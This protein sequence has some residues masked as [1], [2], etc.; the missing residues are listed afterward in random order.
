M[1]IQ[2]LRIK[3]LKKD[4][5]QDMSLFNDLEILIIDVWNSSKH[6]QWIKE[7]LELPL[8]IKYLIIRLN[9]IN[10]LSS[11]KIND[12][13][14]LKIPFGCCLYIE[15]NKYLYTTDEKIEKQNTTHI[16]DT[17][18]DYRRIFHNIS[19]YFCISTNA[20]MKNLKYI[21]GHKYFIDHNI[22]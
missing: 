12:L 1:K 17:N 14:K 3:D 8:N 15:S 21:L 6:L 7:G 9:H 18:M 20:D 4:F 16:Y 2:I 22:I 11:N 19:H 5:L 10:K 13:Y